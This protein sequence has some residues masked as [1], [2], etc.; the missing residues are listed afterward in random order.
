MSVME[1]NEIKYFRI[2]SSITPLPPEYYPMSIW[3]VTTTPDYW[4]LK[5]GAKTL[6]EVSRVFMTG[7]SIQGEFELTLGEL[8]PY[9]YQQ[10]GSSTDYIFD[11][12]PT[13]PAE[14]FIHMVSGSKT[15]TDTV[16]ISNYFTFDDS[17]RN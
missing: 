15:N 10:W 13:F 11:Q 3:H 6:S 16:L 9:G 8:D 1:D 12:Q 7:E 17:L 14:F 2:R 5:A 4:T